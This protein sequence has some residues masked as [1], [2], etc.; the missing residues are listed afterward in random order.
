[1][2][3]ERT[4]DWRRHQAVRLMKR[5]KAEFI[6]ANSWNS[7]PDGWGPILRIRE[8]GR[9][10]DLS[11][12]GCNCRKRSKNNPHCGG[13]I[14]HMMQTPVVLERRDG[15]R[16]CREWMR[17]AVYIDS[18]D[19]LLDIDPAATRKWIDRTW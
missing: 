7:R 2:K 1:M 4:R 17:N 16:Q 11:A 5:R 14:C 13:G 6:N 3:N 18:L 19:D 10:R 12:F 9:L 8:P 15:D